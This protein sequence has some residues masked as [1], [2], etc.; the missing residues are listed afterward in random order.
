METCFS[1]VR[2]VMLTH[3]NYYFD[4]ELTNFMF[5]LFYYVTSYTA[6]KPTKAYFVFCI[7]LLVYC[8]LRLVHVLMT[9]FS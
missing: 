9:L 7:S 6:D 1:I 4:K 5:N 8:I 3:L 2:P